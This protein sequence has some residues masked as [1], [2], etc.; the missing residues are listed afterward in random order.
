MMRACADREKDVTMQKRTNPLALK[1]DAIPEEVSTELSI[2]VKAPVRA[3]ATAPR[4]EAPI[5]NG[6]TTSQVKKAS[7]F[8][9]AGSVATSAPKAPMAA[10]S[11]AKPT[12][13]RPVYPA[14]K[15]SLYVEDDDVMEDEHID[16]YGDEPITQIPATDKHRPYENENVAV[17]DVI[18]DEVPFPTLHD[19]EL[20]ANFSLRGRN[21]RKLVMGKISRDVCRLAQLLHPDQSMSTI[22]ENALMT[23]IFLE[24]PEAFDAMAEVIEEK[25]GR[26]KC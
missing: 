7:E 9:A 2:E 8:T 22:I 23:R 19:F 21:S 18:E 10:P 1:N 26:I 25:G 20:A 11:Y 17:Q 13:E 15:S 5:H 6:I 24:N 4:R 12:N 3:E 14:A 16:L